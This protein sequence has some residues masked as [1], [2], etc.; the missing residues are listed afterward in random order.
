[1]SCPRIIHFERPDVELSDI[2]TVQRVKVR[3][4]MLAFQK[5]HLNDKPVKSRYFSH[6]V[7]SLPTTTQ[8]EAV[9]HT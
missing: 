2:F 1:M 3:W 9:S 8:L 4:V 7:S 5:K 6:S